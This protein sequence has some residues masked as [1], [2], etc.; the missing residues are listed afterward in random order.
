MP[1]IINF[2]GT[3]MEIMTYNSDITFDEYHSVYKKEFGKYISRK[4]KFVR[5]K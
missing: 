3:E 2:F 4:V 1:F 5:Y